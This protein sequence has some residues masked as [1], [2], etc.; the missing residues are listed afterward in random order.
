MLRR[1]RYEYDQAEYSWPRCREIKRSFLPAKL[2]VLRQ[3]LPL[4]TGYTGICNANYKVADA[5]EHARLRTLA[6]HAPRD[7]FRVPDMRAHIHP[8]MWAHA[9]KQQKQNRNETK[10]KQM[11]TKTK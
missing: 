3:I 8:D 4:L 10:T 9:P 6:P 1:G 5:L 7:V 11:K 2:E